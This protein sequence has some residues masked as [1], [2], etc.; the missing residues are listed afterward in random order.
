MTIVNFDEVLTIICDEYDRLI[1][2]KKIRRSNKNIIYLIFKACAKGYELIANIIYALDGKFDPARCQD[3]DLLS[4]AKIVGT[5]LIEGNGSGLI[6]FVTNNNP[7]TAVVL[8]AGRYI[9]K[10][11]DDIKFFLDIEFDT[12]IA[13][14]ESVQFA[15]F[16]ENKGSFPV[17][18]Q[19]SILF[20]RE[21]EA[22]INPML[23]FSCL[24]NSA[25]LGSVDETLYEFRKRI[26]TDNTRSDIIKRLELAIKNKPYIFDASIFFNQYDVAVTVGN[27]TVPPYKMLITLLGFPRDE[28]A[29]L[30]ASHCIYQTVEVPDNGGVLRYLSDNMAGGAYEVF[31]KNFDFIDYK[32]VIDYRYDSRLTLKS[33]AESDINLALLPYKN[34][35][36]R[37]PTIK[38]NLF[39]NLVDD[40]NIPSLNVLNITLLQDDVEIPYLDVN[41]SSIGKLSI[42]ELNGT[43]I[44]E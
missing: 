20:E 18:S 37:I 24:E 34:P 30:V 17:T 36:K 44:A 6:V 22:D 38:E 32:V 14:T 42:V 11:N 16:S 29:E 35:T 40:L 5:E 3:S 31:Y 15:A 8:Y 39:Y 12:S 25:I 41:V 9:Y 1:A 19:S 2:P 27:V 33:V 4:V 43:D 7:S 13:A 21:D 28:I 23:S 26:L 10:F